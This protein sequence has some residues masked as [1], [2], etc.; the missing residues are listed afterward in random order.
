[1]RFSNSVTFHTK[2]IDLGAKV[3][4]SISKLNFKPKSKSF[5]SPVKNL[6]QSQPRIQNKN[7][8]KKLSNQILEQIKNDEIFKKD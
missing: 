6:S 4:E 3:S 8:I 1:M 7:K 2:K 5:Y